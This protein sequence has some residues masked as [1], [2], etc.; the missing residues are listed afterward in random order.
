MILFFDTETTGL[1]LDYKASVTNLKNW[2]RMVQLSWQLW[3]NSEMIKEVD[4]I[5]KCDFDIPLNAL[6]IHGITNEISLQ[7]GIDIDKVLNE[8]EP[9]ILNSDLIV[10]HNVNFDRKILGAEYFRTFGYDPLH[11]TN[12]VCTMMKSTKFCKIK[13]KNGYKWPQLPEL[14]RILF[15]YNF[16]DAHNSLN[17]VRAKWNSSGNRFLTLKK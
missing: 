5:I 15:G 13:S 10:G 8:I 14:H 12:R 9:F 3:N 1:P 7:K 6:K 2:P 11:G 4:R 16:E 17:D